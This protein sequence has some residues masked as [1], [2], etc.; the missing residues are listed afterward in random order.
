MYAG[1]IIE[2][3]KYEEVF[4]NPQH[5]YTWDPKIIP[6]S[7]W[8]LRDSRPFFTIKRTPSNLLYGEIQ[9]DA[10]APRNPG[11]LKIDFT[12]KDHYTSK[13][14]LPIRLKLLLARP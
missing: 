1:D 14:A 7:I 11:A 10:F 12:S 4:Y 3:G 8:E 13:L 5:P 2:I 9:G 6:T